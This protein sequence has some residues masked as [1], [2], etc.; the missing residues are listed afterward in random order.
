MP[1][2]STTLPANDPRDSRS[3]LLVWAW[4]VVFAALLL[5][6]LT[7]A[8]YLALRKPETVYRTLPP[9]PPDAQQQSLLDQARTTGESLSAEIAAL[10]AALA[11]YICPPGTIKDP[12]APAISIPPADGSGSLAPGNG[13]L[14][15]EVSPKAVQQEASNATAAAA[16]APGTPAHKLAQRELVDV[17]THAVVLVLTESSSASGFF[18]APNYV[19]TNRHAVEGAKDGR[20]GVTSKTLG[21]LHVGK[22]VATTSAGP[23]GSDDYAVIRLDDV[24][25]PVTLPLSL[26]HDALT[27]I[28]SAGY[29]GLTIQNDNGFRQL[30]SG[31]A[32][33]APE[34]VLSRGEIQAVQPS[35]TGTEVLV[36]SGDVMQGS[37]GGPIVDACG[38]AIGMNTYIAVDEQQSGRVSYALAAGGL[39]GFLRQAGVPVVVQAGQCAE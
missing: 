23:K 15:M 6:I 34:L 14:G 1:E 13:Q 20:V 38:R 32:A 30:L 28:V 16:V 39:A 21:Q 37:S 24:N 36:H 3:R 18:I 35:A 17:L 19:V 27:P 31:D 25:S 33:A 26:S 10:R 11:A 29:P 4:W 9:P 2:A 5:A 8:V 22:V 12:A 7:L